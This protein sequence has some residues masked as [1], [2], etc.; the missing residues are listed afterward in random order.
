MNKSPS[1][2]PKQKSP[3]SSNVDE[4]MSLPLQEFSVDILRLI[5]AEL[6]IEEAQRLC[7]THPKLREK[8]RRHDLVNAKAREFVKQQSPLS[9]P[10]YTSV[11][12]ELLLRRGFK[13]TYNYVEGRKTGEVQFGP[14]EQEVLWGKP[15]GVTF[16]SIVGMPPPEGTRVVIFYNTSLPPEEQDE[17]SV[18]SSYEELFAILKDRSLINQDKQLAHFLD[19]LSVRYMDSIRADNPEADDDALDDLLLEQARFE[20]EKM[21]ETPDDSDA[22]FNLVQVELP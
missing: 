11:D 16:F 15:W 17:A 7:S 22:Y 18:Y 2:S 20:L 13:T 8:C 3:E 1:R 4:L 19:S 12:Q 9:Q 10:F 6:T 14:V 21:I 5:M